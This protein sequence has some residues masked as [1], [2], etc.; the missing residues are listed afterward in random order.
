MTSYFPPPGDGW[1]R[2]EAEAAGFDPAR[3]AEAVAFAEANE[4][5]WPRSM[6]LDDGQYVGTADMNEGPP[7]NEVLG[8]VRP[9]GPTSGLVIRGGRIAA[10]W[11]DTNRPD[12]TFSIA[13][14]YLGVL[15]GL[16]VARGLIRSVD[17]PVRGYVRDDGFEALQNRAITWRHLLHQT[18]EW[19]GTLWGKADLADRNRHVGPGVG[20]R[21]KGT[22]R[23]LR[24]PGTY[25]EYNDV[26]VNRLSFSLM[27]VFR[28]PLPEVLREAVMDP[29][30]A[31]SGWEWKGYRNSQVEIDGRAMDSVSGGAHWGGG[32][33][34]STRDH[35]R[36]AL[37]IQRRGSWDGR[38]LVP[39][40]WI[41]ELSTPCPIKP[42]YGY[43]WW[44]NTGR[45]MYPSAP[46]TSIFCLGLGTNLIW[47]DAA[48]DL[49]VVARWIAKDQVDALIGKVM[50][51]IARR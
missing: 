7:W 38:E 26:R 45:G 23:D 48:L 35:A 37:L 50:A 41:A 8:E 28:R 11:G 44:L 24:E 19:E 10:E 30:G 29:I 22:H 14:S 31:S 39:A 36:F 32:M 12:M 16:A 4:S 1:A 6:Y 40:R 25:W 47:L 49:V 9:R 21:P 33:F 51:G 46:A 34:I 42:I 3:L 43:M 15:A 20:A 27:Q 17:D 18:S 13:K 2:V 5:R